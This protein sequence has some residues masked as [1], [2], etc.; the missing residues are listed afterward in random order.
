MGDIG[1][2]VLIMATNGFEQSELMVPLQK[3][4]EAGC[5]VRVAAPEPGRIRGWKEKDWGDSVEVDLTL[6]DV[7]VKNYAALVLP[8]GQINPDLLRT[9]D[10]ALGIVLQFVEDGR[11]VAAISMPRGSSS[12]PA[13]PAGAT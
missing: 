7:D 12:R 13:S 1:D 4:R 8:G 10:N 3:L 9:N 2:K 11:I 6:D 5:H